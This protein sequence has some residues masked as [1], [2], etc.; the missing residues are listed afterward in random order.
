M[1]VDQDGIRR[2]RKSDVLWCAELMTC[3]EPWITL[4]RDRESSF[5]QLGDLFKELYVF[6]DGHEH[7]GF[8]LIDMRGTFAGY[9]QSLC[10]APPFQNRRYGATLLQFVERRIFR[11]YP[12]VFLCVSSFNREA[13]RFYERHGYEQ[14]GDL[15]DF[16]I[17]GAS[18]LL[19]RKSL[20][21]KSTFKP[22]SASSQMKASTPW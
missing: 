6:V 2:A 16:I 4:R 1:N 13:L 8:V 17:A 14:V 18:E 22:A 9:I 21:P 10:V 3:S 20:G 19:L 15:R 7:L 11:D 12:N 5:D